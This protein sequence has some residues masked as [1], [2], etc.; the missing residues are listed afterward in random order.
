MNFEEFCVKLEYDFFEHIMFRKAWD[1][2][3]TA[4]FKRLVDLGYIDQNYKS[5]AWRDVQSILESE[6]G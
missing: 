6:N 5:D 1:A 4:M 2:G 3:A